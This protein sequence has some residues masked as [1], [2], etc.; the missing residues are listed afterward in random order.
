LSENAC[1]WRKI[2][3]FKQKAVKFGA[4]KELWQPN[5]QTFFNVFVLCCVEEGS[6]KNT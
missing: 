4:Q 1:L 6:I 5:L 2:D 3:C